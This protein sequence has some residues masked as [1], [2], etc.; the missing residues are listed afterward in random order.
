MHRS[1]MAAEE[2]IFVE[3]RFRKQ[4]WNSAIRRIRNI[5]I[6]TMTFYDL[7]DENLLRM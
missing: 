7:F 4:E 6:K 1:E 2:K 5:S 3:I